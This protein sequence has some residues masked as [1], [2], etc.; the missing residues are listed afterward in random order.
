[1]E[2][3]D[4]NENVASGGIIISDNEKG[5]PYHEGDTGQFT[6]KEGGSD[7]KKQTGLSSFFVKLGDKEAKEQKQSKKMVETLMR[8]PY[9][10][11][12]K[13][14]E[15]SVEELSQV[16]DAIIH[17][18]NSEQEI[19]DKLDKFNKGGVSG[20]W[21]TTVWPSDYE[22]LL[23]G[24]NF[25]A[26]KKYFEEVYA[27]PDKEE[28]L[29]LLEDFQKR[30]EKYIEEKKKAG[31][32]YSQYEELVAKYRDNDTY[33]QERKD[34]ATWITGS[35]VVTKSI[36]KFGKQA[37][38]YL[39]QLKKANPKAY[40]AAMQY[41]SSYSAFNEP[42]RDMIYLGNEQKV[43]L[44]KIGFVDR[45]ANLTAAID[46]ST[47][48][49]DVWLQRGLSNLT[50]DNL[51]GSEGKKLT[52]LVGYK[53][54]LSELVG[55]Q[56]KDHG[57]VSAGAGSGTGFTDEPVCLYIY[58]PKG[59]KMLYMNTQGHYAHSSENEM[60]LQRGYTYSIT[61][62]EKKGGKICLDCEVI[63]G[64]DGDKYD[65]DKLEELSNTHFQSY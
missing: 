60:I 28:K 29:A 58:A 47:Y 59:T 40:D 8:T 7:G 1:M 44:K 61:K 34:K 19:S 26:K 43:A 39:G 27:G 13:L 46:G 51:N 31:Q 64:T 63:L 50:I 38:D 12:A 23:K 45:V 35:N 16:Q 33:S 6:S 41:T 3:K 22:K 53:E 15:L 55:M 2:E 4:K 54:D 36:K 65:V 62:A 56:F 14:S 30:G 20:L 37:D 42:L 48:D 49:E 52:S 18:K 32:D 10:D 5:N 9:M 24:G 25:E 57:F 11:K 21:K 17:L